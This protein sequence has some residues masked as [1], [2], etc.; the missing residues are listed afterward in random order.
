MEKQ[1][2]LLFF[3]LL[4]MM[5][6]T[7]RA[8]NNLLF[9]KWFNVEG[10]RIWEFKTEGE[11]FIISTN[12]NN[13]TKQKLKFIN[14]KDTLSLFN[15][16]ALLQN[17]NIKTLKPNSMVLFDAHSKTTI[18]FISIK[19]QLSKRKLSKFLSGNSFQTFS[20]NKRKVIVFQPSGDFIF[21]ENTIS[22]LYHYQWQL[23]NIQGFNFLFI[24]KRL[25][26]VIINADNN[27]L[28][29][30]QLDEKWKHTVYEKINYDISKAREDIVGKWTFTLHQ[31]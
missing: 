29:I 3:F 8:E 16:N 1:I 28:T 23:K 19:N 21:L 15:G 2:K 31:K 25:H 27:T 24:D 13:T 30:G 4:L 26:S 5:L 10:K 7:A 11:L 18:H 9:Q 17:F 6:S 20:K 22:N 14:N 12:P